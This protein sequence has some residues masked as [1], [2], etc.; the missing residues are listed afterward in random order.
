MHVKKNISLLDT[1]VN[2]GSLEKEILEKYGEPT[3][4]GM[5]ESAMKHVK[6]L[7]DLDF[8]DI[9]ISLK[10]SNTMLTIKAYEFAVFKTFPYP[11]HVGVTEEGLSFRRHY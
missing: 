5:V 4:E 6:I 9:V 3:P 8:H 7:E 1:G 10:S 11:L 2:G